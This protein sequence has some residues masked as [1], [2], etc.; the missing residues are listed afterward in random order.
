[1][2]EPCDGHGVI[3]HNGN[4]FWIQSFIVMNVKRYFKVLQ[5][6]LAINRIRLVN[7]EIFIFARGDWPVHVRSMLTADLFYVPLDYSPP[8]DVRVIK[9]LR[10]K[11]YNNAEEYGYISTIANPDIYFSSYAMEKVHEM[12]M[13]FGLKIPEGVVNYNMTRERERRDWLYR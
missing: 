3:V 11:S 4:C 13:K 7:N 10:A 2:V 5:A 8:G 12:N 6:A 9:G 1:M